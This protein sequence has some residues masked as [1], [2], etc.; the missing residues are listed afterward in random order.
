MSGDQVK[1]APVQGH[2]DSPLPLKNDNQNKLNAYTQKD[3]MSLNKKSDDGV[4]MIHDDSFLCVCFYSVAVLHLQSIHLADASSQ[5]DQISI[6]VSTADRKYSR[7]ARIMCIVL[8]VFWWSK[9]VNGLSSPGTVPSN[10]ISA[11]RHGNGERGRKSECWCFFTCSVCRSPACDPSAGQPSRSPLPD[12]HRSAQG[13]H[14]PAWC[15]FP[16]RQTSS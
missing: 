15:S 8:T 10:H 4:Y 9:S 12:R 3:K 2:P 13:Q 11:T 14:P 16:H 7:K 1:L 5:S 6:N